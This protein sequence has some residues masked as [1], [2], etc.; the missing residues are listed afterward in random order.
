MIRKLSLVLAILLALCSAAFAEEPRLFADFSGDWVLNIIVQDNYHMNMQAWGIHI[1]LT[2]NEDGTAT[3]SYSED[4]ATEMTWRFQDG[5]A[6]ITGYSAEGEIEITFGED[7]S[8]CL[9]D[10]IGAMYFLRP[11]AAEE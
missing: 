5:R 3:L 10:E 6:F 7:G 11:V 8:L 4:D 9:A 2:L 1:P